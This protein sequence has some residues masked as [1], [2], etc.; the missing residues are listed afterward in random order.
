MVELSLKQKERRYQDLK[1]SQFIVYSNQLK[2]VSENQ[3]RKQQEMKRLERGGI[4]QSLLQYLKYRL[5]SEQKWHG[6]FQK[7]MNPKIS[8]NIL[9]MNRR[10]L[11]WSMRTQYDALPN[12]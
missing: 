6:I 11:M 5:A 4:Q 9:V 1:R 7:K 10:D 3:K 2:E 8:P 12:S